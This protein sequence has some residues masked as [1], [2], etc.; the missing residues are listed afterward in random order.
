MA[1]RD[2]TILNK[3]ESSSTSSETLSQKL[4]KQGSMFFLDSEEIQSRIVLIKRAVMDYLQTVNGE[5]EILYEAAHHLIL[6][7]GKRLRSLL[8]LLC[9]EAVGG[10]VEEVLPITVAAELLQTASLIHDDIID[11]DELRRGVPTVHKKYGYDIAILAGDFLISQAF[12]IIGEHGSPELVANI[13]SGGVRM[14]EGEASDLF[15]TPERKETYTTEEYM[16]MIERKTAVFLEEAARTGAIVGEATEGEHTAL[17]RYGSLIGIAFQLKD[18][19]LDIHAT[20]HHL[21]KSTMSDLRLKRGNY[22]LIYALEQC[23]AEQEESCLDALD[24]NQW[25]EIIKLILQY[26]AIE[27]TTQLARSYAEQAKN[28]LQGYKFKNKSLLERLADFTV[29]RDF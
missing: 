2:S 7:G 11:K 23:S 25:N 16:K 3:T 9:C 18:D 13:G 17:A 10:S 1:N 5:P 29:Q 6:A 14:C 8:T 24:N 27:Y 21:K 20:Q 19:I 15:I 4:S 22:P 12:R 28:A 26:K